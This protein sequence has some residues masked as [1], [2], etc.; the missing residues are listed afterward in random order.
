MH[1]VEVL[2]VGESSLMVPATVEGTSVNLIVDSGS[3][4]SILPRRL[5]TGDL[6]ETAVELRA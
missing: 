1:S 4:V 3:P 6:S 5:V 2:T